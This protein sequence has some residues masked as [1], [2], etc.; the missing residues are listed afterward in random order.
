MS[1][2]ARRSVAATAIVLL[3]AAG[4]VSRSGEERAA[5]AGERPTSSTT[6]RTTAE[7]TTTERTTPSAADGSDV[8]ECA[9]GTCEILVT[10][11]RMALPTPAGPLTLTITDEGVEYELVNPSGGTNS[12]SAEGNCVIAIALDG[13]G[14]GSTCMA[15][16]EPPDLAPAPGTMELQILE[17]DSDTP[18]LR[19]AAN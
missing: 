18:I 10:S 5:P 7:R 11:R 14:G 8:T 16:G 12:G 3:L 4:C 15:G 19:L 2:S 9:D 6:E 17:P 1:V 13:S